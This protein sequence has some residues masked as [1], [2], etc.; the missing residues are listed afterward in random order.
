MK[1][2]HFLSGGVGEILVVFRALGVVGAKLG[3][4]VYLPTASAQVAII[5]LCS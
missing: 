1:C 3:V 5:Q 2:L 4:P